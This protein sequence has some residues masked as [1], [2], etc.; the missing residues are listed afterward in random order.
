MGESA[1]GRAD[2]AKDGREAS[3]ADDQSADP[4]R[5]DSA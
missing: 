1:N 2:R 5:A 3:D 4:P